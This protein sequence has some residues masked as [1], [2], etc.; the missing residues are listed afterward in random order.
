M[1]VRT[2]TLWILGVVALG[3]LSGCASRVTVKRHEREL[4]AVTIQIEELRKSNESIA[5]ELARTAAELKELEGG[6]ARQ[7]RQ[8]QET[9]RQLSQAAARLAE[10]E[11]T[12]R[13]LRASVSELAREASRAATRPAPSEPP[14]RPREPPAQR[15][16][17]EQLYASAVANMRAREHGQAVLDFLDLIAKYPKHPLAANAQYWIGEAYYAQRDFRQ[18]LIE[19]QK[20]VTQYGASTKT[21][22]ALYK[23]G[24]CYR[25]LHEPR[26]AQEAWDRLIREFPESEAARKARAFRKIRPATASTRPR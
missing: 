25:A 22:D 24:L 12:I 7:A 1:R 11:G 4:S 10:V 13:E 6:T 3:L 9:S 26:R 21:P 8:E 20:V 19:F 14:L 15:E 2:G 5:R 18:A 23:I 16:S 17:A